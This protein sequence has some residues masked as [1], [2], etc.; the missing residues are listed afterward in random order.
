MDEPKEPQ[1]RSKNPPPY[2]KQ[3][4]GTASAESRVTWD[5]VKETAE[6][7]FNVF[8]GQP[9][10]K[11]AE[12]AWEAIG[13]S[14]LTGFDSELA[15][16]RVL[17]RL[18]ALACLYREFCHV[19]FDEYFDRAD[20]TLDWR[21]HCDPDPLWLGYLAGA[22]G[23]EVDEDDDDQSVSTAAALVEIVRTEVVDALVKGFGGKDM[24]FASLWCSS[25]PE[26]VDLPQQEALEEAL[27][28]RHA[29]AYSWVDQGM[30]AK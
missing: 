7:V 23:I 21:G 28:A 8:V 4:P 9:E 2:G 12:K 24:L 13:R 3:R 29:S 25:S 14:G 17:V 18:L 6:A 5:D 16:H 30:P 20:L 10:L 19:A 22:A 1:V 15:R 26:T 11:W 27:S